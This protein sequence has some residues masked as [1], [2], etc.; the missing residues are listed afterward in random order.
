M[1]ARRAY[2]HGYCILDDDTEVQYK[3]TDF[4]SPAHDRGIAWH[5]PVCADAIYT[6]S[7]AN[8]TGN[9]AEV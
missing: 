2:A 5:D 7:L 3:T 8:P 6:K 1:I 9:A 4:Y